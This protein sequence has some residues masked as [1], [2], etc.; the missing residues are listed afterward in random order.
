MIYC[1][2]CGSQ[3]PDN[4]AFCRTCGNKL[5]ARGLALNSCGIQH[6]FMSR[7][8]YPSAAFTLSLVAGIFV[9]LGGII[10]AAIGAVFTFFA[11]GVGAI[12]GIFGIIWGIIIIVGA[13]NLRSHPEQH[14]T[15]G[16]I[17]LVFSI[18]S[19]FGAVGG[20]FIGFLL[21]LIGGILAL[22]WQ[23]PQ[24]SVA[25][26]YASPSPPSST[27]TMQTTRF[28]PNCG[29]PVQPN[30]TFCPNCGKPLTQ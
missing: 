29:A 1:S 5:Q 15:W 28:C 30:S 27:P 3:N 19:W 2:N 13:N 26:T 20:L 10:G 9:L 18:V 7:E 23:P 17:I 24:S 16:V 11:F 21:G 12:I 14:V 25:P 22:S 8:S 6:E 4:A